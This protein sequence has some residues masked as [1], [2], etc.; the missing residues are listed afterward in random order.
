LNDINTSKLRIYTYPDPFLRQVAKPI[1][2]IDQKI[3]DLAEEMIR[4]MIENSGI[5]LAATQIG[6]S[7]RMFVMSLSGKTEDAQVI[8][9]PKLDNFQDW[10]EM[11][12]G[13]LSVP[14]VRAKVR[15]YSACT[16]TA[17]DLEGNRFV[18]DVV[19]L[20][21]TCVQHET[22]HL[23]GILFIN[24]LSALSKLACRRALKQLEEEYPPK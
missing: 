8:I 17:L 22:D 5:G 6:V 19:D 23:D 20:A 16:V 9:N 18:M 24:R 10:S 13:C 12:E 4:I 21:S 3:H 2:K 15:R 1:E 7:L 14:G 11:E